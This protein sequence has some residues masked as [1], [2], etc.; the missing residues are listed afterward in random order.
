MLRYLTKVV[1]RLTDCTTRHYHQLSLFASMA[2]KCNIVMASVNHCWAAA[3]FT[4]F[5]MQ[6]SDQLKGVYCCG[7]N[8]WNKIIIWLQLAIILIII[9]SFRLNGLVCEI[10]TFVKNGHHKF[11]GPKVQ[12]TCFVWATSRKAHLV[13]PLSSRHND[14]WSHVAVQ[15]VQ[16]SFFALRSLKCNT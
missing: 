7:L 11:P 8:P 14:K 13:L 5:N 16:M 9:G 15:S 12:I 3:I 1:E 4:F 6:W 2:K 10:V